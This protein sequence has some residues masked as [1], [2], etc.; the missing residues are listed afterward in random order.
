MEERDEP[1][2]ISLHTHKDAKTAAALVRKLAGKLPATAPCTLTPP[3]DMYECKFEPSLSHS[4]ATLP[5]SPLQ[6]SVSARLT[7]KQLLL[8]ALL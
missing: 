6:S 1:A 7:E 3:V 5:Y 4:S 2:S 8:L